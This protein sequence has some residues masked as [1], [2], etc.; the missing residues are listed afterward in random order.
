MHLKT[1]SLFGTLPIALLDR[2]DE[3]GEKELL[4]LS[5]YV[6]HPTPNSYLIL[7]ASSLKYLADFYDKGKKEVV[8][9]DLS[10][11]KPWQREKRMKKVCAA[12]IASE[13]KIISPALLDHLFKE[14]PLEL[15]LIEQEIS[16]LL[17]YVGEKKEISM[18]DM[19]AVVCF[20]KAKEGWQRADEIV[21]GGKL[22][23]E[24][25]EMDATLLFGLIGQI[26]YYL[27]KGLMVASLIEKG[28][29]LQEIAD[30][31]AE[32][33]NSLLE[34][35]SQNPRSLEFFKRGLVLLFEL[36]L[37]AKSNLGSPELLFT[38]FYGKMY[39]SHPSS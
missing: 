23:M 29:S 16:K 15:G 30:E 34:K 19:R 12:R 32:I 37:S 26:R 20:G 18:D 21:W 17:C 13:G 4:S 2:I 24:K 39:E 8:I 5:E 11:E 31:Y 9:L 36:E 28:K 27:E 6:A 33:S 22:S 38:I 35:F 3:I 10:L 25:E 14:L 7:G 1:Q